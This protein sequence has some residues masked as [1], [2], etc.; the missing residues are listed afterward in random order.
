MYNNIN[1]SIVDMIWLQLLAHD[2]MLW[3]S[4]TTVN[5]LQRK[6]FS[7]DNTNII[8]NKLK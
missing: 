4:N 2:A 8:V 6:L 5:K 3:V 7:I 1:T